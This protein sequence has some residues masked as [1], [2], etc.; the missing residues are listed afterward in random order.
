MEVITSPDGQLQVENP[1]KYEQ[2]NTPD[3]EFKICRML[4]LYRI[5]T[6]TRGKRTLWVVS[7]GEKHP[8]VGQYQKWRHAK[9]NGNLNVKYTQ[10]SSSLR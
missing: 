1:E 3:G 6:I 7:G 8:S 4:D 9:L 10:T 2:V 5:L